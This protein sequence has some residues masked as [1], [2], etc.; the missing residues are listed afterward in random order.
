MYVVLQI[1]EYINIE[2]SYQV[3]MQSEDKEKVEAWVEAMTKI[4]NITGAK[5][6]YHIFKKLD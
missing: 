5:N 6:K 4:N 1:I 3:K 2:D